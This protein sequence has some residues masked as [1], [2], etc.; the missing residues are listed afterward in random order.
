MHYL[1]GHKRWCVSHPLCSIYF[2]TQI[3]IE[4]EGFI[5]LADHIIVLTKD[6]SLEYSGNPRSWERFASI[7][8]NAYDALE[9]DSPP[10]TPSTLID[11]ESKEGSTEG[12]TRPTGQ[13]SSENKKTEK[14]RQTGDITTWIYFAKAI[15]RIPLFFFILFIV[16]ASLGVEFPKLLLKWS[17]EENFSVEKFI[18]LYAMLVLIAWASQ[19]AMIA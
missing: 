3:L 16:L 5:T 13:S 14:K 4:T 19:G 2:V 6:G 8:K 10:P 17:T 11:T 15:G 18:G 9:S 12:S 1:D 7:S